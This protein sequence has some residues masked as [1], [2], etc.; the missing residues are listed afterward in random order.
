MPEKKSPL[1]GFSALLFV[2]LFLISL[3]FQIG[4]GAWRS[5]FGGHA[6]EGAH[7]VT[8]LMVRDYLGGGFLETWHP[9]RYAEAYYERFPKVA[10]GHYPPG[11]YLVASAGLLPFRSGATLLVIMNLL[12]AG[13][14]VLVWW[15][16]RRI[17]EHDLPAVALALLYVLLP[18][19]RTYTAIVMA[20]LLLVLLGALAARSFLIFLRSGRGR[21]AFFFG[22]WAACAI[23]TKGSGIGLALLPLFALILS[24]KWRQFFSPRLWLAPVPVLVVALPWMLL[25]MGITKEGMQQSGI[26]DWAKAALPYYGEA[27]VAEAGWFAVGALAAAFAFGGL[28]MLLRR[29]VL[30]DEEAVLWALFAC[31]I[32]IPLVI[33]AGL[34]Q[35]YLMPVIPSILLLAASFVRR[36][37][38]ERSPVL[39]IAAV[40]L[41]ALMVVAETRRPVQKLYTGATDAVFRVIKDAG[42]GGREGEPLRVLAVSNATGEGALIAAAALHAPDSLVLARGT[43]VLSSSDWMGRGYQVAFE[44]PEDL[45]TLLGEEQIDYLIIDPPAGETSVAHWRVLHGWLEAGAVIS[46]RPIGAVPSWRRQV[47]SRFS[48]YR[49]GG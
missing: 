35:R 1:K 14:G 39:G 9:M 36:I 38:A 15:F 28:Q 4:S 48:L 32:V 8:G 34:D 24:G 40:C 22:F 25:T 13:T 46:L 23:L 47:E 45:K 33:P 12:G 44:T 30:R 2:G 41:F 11:F 29:Q 31:G 43:K 18:Q 37:A 49:V 7:V 26:L 16:G 42:E 5:D 21:D 6:D 17:L 3:G 10:L 20:D 27:L 19:T